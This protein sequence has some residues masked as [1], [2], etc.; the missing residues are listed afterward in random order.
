MYLM[1]PRSSR[2]EPWRCASRQ[3]IASIGSSLMRDSRN[4][5]AVDKRISKVP[6]LV[7]AR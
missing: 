3:L 5:H 6:P 1:R 2:A 4:A 7:S